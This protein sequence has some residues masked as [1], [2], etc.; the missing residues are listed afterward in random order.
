MNGKQG[1]HPLTDILSYG[2]PTFNPEVDNLIKQLDRLGVWE[3]QLISFLMLGLHGELRR[4][5]DE[6]ADQQA[7]TLLHNFAWTLRGELERLG[8]SSPA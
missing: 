2:L 5:R 7:D 6:G 8:R 4:L 3:G 1:D